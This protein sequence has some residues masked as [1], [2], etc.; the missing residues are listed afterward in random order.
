[1]LRMHNSTVWRWNRACYGITNGIAHLR[2]ENRALPSGPTVADEIANAAFFTGLMAA[3]PKEYGDV[4]QRMEFDDAKSNFF[5][6]AR[7]GLDA[8]FNWIDGKNHSAASLVLDHLLPLARQGLQTS[9]VDS[10]DIDNYLGII[11]E[12]AQSRQTGARWILKSLAAMPEIEPRDVRQRRLTSAMLT[13]QKQGQPVHRWP[14]AETS[15]IGNWAQGYRTV[16]QFMSTDLFTVQP[17]DL[18]DLAASVMDWRHI[19]HVPV[20]NQEGR[21]VGLVTHRNLLRLVSN[22]KREKNINVITVQEIMVANP[23]TVTPSTPTLKAIEIMREQRIGCL[24]V[25]EDNQ[26]VGI[27]TSYDFLD[28]AARLFQEHL[29]PAVEPVKVQTMKQS[30]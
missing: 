15:E 16:G 27:V 1:A 14:V 12:R 29:T 4:A 23:V 10:G 19:R 6:A 28:A 3:L 25:V 7:H 20:E 22:G 18:I 11:K 2:I 24:P 5:R 9:K 21:L 26:L 30:A 8:Q 13:H 17:D